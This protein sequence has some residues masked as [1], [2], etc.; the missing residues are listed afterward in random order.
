M[1]R[2]Q[3]FAHFLRIQSGP[4]LVAVRER[5]NSLIADEPCYLQDREVGITCSAG[6][7]LNFSSVGPAS[8]FRG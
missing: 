3:S 4:T 8:S 1:A 6:S 7:M 2:C 5:A